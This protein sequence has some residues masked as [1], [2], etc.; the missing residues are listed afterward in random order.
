MIPKKHRHVKW[1]GFFGLRRLMAAEYHAQCQHQRHAAPPAARLPLLLGGPPKP[2]HCVMLTLVHTAHTWFIHGRFRGSTLD[3]PK[4]KCLAQDGDREDTKLLLLDDKLQELSGEGARGK[5][6][7]Q[8]ANMGAKEHTV[9]SGSGAEC[10]IGTQ[11]MSHVRSG[12]MQSACWRE[13]KEGVQ[14][15]D[16]CDAAQGLRKELQSAH[17]HTSTLA[18]PHGLLQ[19][20]QG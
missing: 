11:G 4:V 1:K 19:L 17:M 12:H 14:R 5:H 3:K 2:N 15:I 8:G 7:G 13:G 16:S 18:D 20:L 6:P 9:S 10:G